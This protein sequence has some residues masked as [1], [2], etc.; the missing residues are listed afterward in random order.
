MMEGLEEF[1]EY[2]VKWAH[3]ILVYDASYLRYNCN[4]Y[5]LL[6]QRISN[7]ENFHHIRDT[8][9]TDVSINHHIQLL[10][11]I[12]RS[13]HIWMINLRHSVSTLICIV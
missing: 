12:L 5:Y 4:N 3:G 9:F 6:T 1:Q 13:R 7:V 10:F 11:I 2:F 8:R